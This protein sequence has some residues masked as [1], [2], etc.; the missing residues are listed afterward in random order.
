MKALEGD[1]PAYSAEALIPMPSLT[2]GTLTFRAGD[3]QHALSSTHTLCTGNTLALTPAL[4]RRY[5]ALHFADRNQQLTEVK[6][7]HTAGRDGDKFP[8]SAP[9]GMIILNFTGIIWGVL[10]IPAV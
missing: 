2:L 7:G 3:T 4:H 6:E 8:L 10:K 5:D 9:K 1:Q